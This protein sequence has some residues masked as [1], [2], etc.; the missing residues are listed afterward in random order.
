MLQVEDKIPFFRRIMENELKFQLDWLTRAQTAELAERQ[1]QL[2]KQLV[3]ETTARSERQ[4]ELITQDRRNRLSQAEALRKHALLAQ[5]EALM[6]ELR[7][8]LSVHLRDWLRS[9]D[10]LDKLRSIRF[11]RVD[12]PDEMKPRF[13]ERFSVSYRSKA[14]DGFVLYDDEEATRLDLTLPRWLERYERS[15]AEVFQERVG[16]L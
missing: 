11:Q 8:E 14:I 4:K 16:G 7:R 13:L 12:G 5:R 1:E 9:D 15:L 10:F 6:A 2:E 3:D